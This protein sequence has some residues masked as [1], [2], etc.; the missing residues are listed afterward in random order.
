MYSPFRVY[1]FYIF[2]YLQFTIF[3]Q[4]SSSPGFFSIFLMCGMFAKFIIILYTNSSLKLCHFLCRNS[5][6]HFFA[7]GQLSRTCLTFYFLST[8]DS[9]LCM[10]FFLHH[11]DSIILRPPTLSHLFHFWHRIR[12][13]SSLPDA[14]F[15]PRLLRAKEM[16]SMNFEVRSRGLPLAVHSSSCI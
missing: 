9:F 4:F 12:C 2:D 11:L 3:P 15:I 8:K 5:I 1:K 10:F 6:L 7:S 16:T 14:C 13:I